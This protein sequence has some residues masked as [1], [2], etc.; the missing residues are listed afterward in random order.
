MPSKIPAASPADD[1]VDQLD[2]LLFAFRGEMHRVMREAELPVSPMELRVLLHV[3]RQPGCTA[4]DLARHSGRD[5]GQLTRLIQ[6]LEQEGLIR[7][8]AH[9]E[10]R[11]AQCLFTTEAGEAVHA[12]MRSERRALARSLLSRLDAAEQ[13]QLAQLLGKLKAGRPQ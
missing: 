1:V 6:N 12:R 10:D 11:R 2:A 7:R 5:K 9:A 8:E 4:G 13:A 3:A